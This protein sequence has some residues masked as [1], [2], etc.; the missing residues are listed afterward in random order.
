MDE[1]VRALR[2]WL[3]EYLKHRDLFKKS[4]M[5]M[6]AKDAEVFV[7]Y[8]DRTER[9]EIVPVLTEIPDAGEEYLSIVTLNT[10]AN[11]RHMIAHWAGFARQERLTVIFINP[12]SSSE[13]KWIIRPHL[14]ERIS[15]DDSLKAGLSAMFQTVEEYRPRQNI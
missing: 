5:S 10:E 2:E 8:R 12:E 14:H 11:L 6:E 4:I 3:I 7:R 9:F 1:P 13:T 15:D